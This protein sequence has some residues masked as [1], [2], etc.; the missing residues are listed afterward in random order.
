MASPFQ[1]ASTMPL[2]RRATVQNVGGRP[3]AS[4]M[5]RGRSSM[6]QRVGTTSLVDAPSTP[7]LAATP[8]TASSGVPA[9]D[10][11]PSP[12][13]PEASEAIDGKPLAQS[14]TP[15][16]AEE[17][18]GLTP[19]SL[20]HVKRQR[21]ALAEEKVRLLAE[22]EELKRKLKE[23]KERVVALQTQL[24]QAEAEK[25]ELQ[26]RAEVAEEREQEERL[27]ADK[28]EEVNV[29]LEE[30]LAE[31]E[32]EIERLRKALEDQQRLTQEVCEAA[33]RRAAG[34]SESDARVK[35]LEEQVRRLEAENRKLREEMQKQASQHEEMKRN[36]AVAMAAAEKAMA[37]HAHHTTQV[38]TLRSA[39]LA[40]AINQKVELH[41]SVPRVTLSYNNAP[42]LLISVATALGEG[43]IQKFLDTEVFP[44]FE[45]LWVR[46]DSLD[47]APDGS[48][49]RAYS[50]RMLDR[51]TQAVKAFVVKS[52]QADGPDSLDGATEEASQNKGSS[53]DAPELRDTDRERLLEL[54]RSG[55]DNALDAKLQEVMAARGK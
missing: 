17:N 9:L 22:I 47:K 55:D 16:A 1:R 13:T 46:M 35:E 12:G 21:D 19:A 28:A 15:P 53:R 29:K 23:Q 18:F 42:P 4:H 39:K 6:F 43:K 20:K 8:S 25:L 14:P 3:P 50:T 26:K 38:E 54:L 2:N 11:S 41:I 33:E 34:N 40:E 49:K 7:P 5:A 44:H 32:A 10:S 27:R 45:P 51:L 31:R 37:M 52:Q 30:T 24:E 36:V 48:S